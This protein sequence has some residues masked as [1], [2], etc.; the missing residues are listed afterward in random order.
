MKNKTYIYISL[1]IL[2]VGG[3]LAYKEFKK[4]KVLTKED[5]VKIIINAE[6]HGSSATISSFDLAFLRAWANAVVNKEDTFSYN[7]KNYKTQG[8]RAIK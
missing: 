4:A 8:G 2:A 5:A 6:K 7:G 3:Y 1:A